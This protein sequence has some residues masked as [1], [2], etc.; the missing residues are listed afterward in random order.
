MQKENSVIKN[1]ILSSEKYLLSPELYEKTIETCLYYSLS[2]QNTDL[3]CLF[4]LRK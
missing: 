1:Y 3:I 2:E 4:L